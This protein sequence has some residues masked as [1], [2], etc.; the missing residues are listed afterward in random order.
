MRR[1]ALA[2][3]A[4]ALASAAMLWAKAPAPAPAAEQGAAAFKQRCAACHGDNG[5]A[6]RVLSRRVAKGQATLESRTDLNPDIVRIAV[7][8]GIGMMPAIR[9][10]ELPDAELAAIGG[11]LSKR[12]RK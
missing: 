12:K 8:N 6:T 1:L 4:L 3:P 10:A 2:V 7:R 5:W 9:K 11:Y